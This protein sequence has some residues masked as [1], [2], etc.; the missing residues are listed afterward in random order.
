M[1]HH[2]RIEIDTQIL[3][4]NI[5]LIKQFMRQHTNSLVKYCLPVKANA[6]GHGLV[7]TANVVQHEVDYFGVAQADEGIKLRLAG[8]TKPILVFG[9]FADD[10]IEQLISH[11]LEITVSSLYKARLIANFCAAN[12]CVAKVHVKIDTGMNRI[13]VRV[14]SAD[15]LIDFVT[16]HQCFILSGIYSHLAKSDAAQDKFTHKQIEQFAVIAL[17]YK[18]QYPELLCHLANSGGVTNY[19]SSCL[20]DMVRP[21][22]LTYGYLPLVPDSDNILAGIRPCFSVYSQVAYFK[23]VEAQQGISYNHQYITT[24][25]TRVVTIPV[26]YG[27]GYRRAL[28]N[29]GEVIIRGNKYKVAGTICMDMFM[30]DIGATGEAHVGDEVVLI[31]R[32]GQQTIY[33][34]DIATMCDTITYE[35]LCAFNERIPRVYI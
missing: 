10:Q 32:Q 27:D 9:A 23:V 16:Q 19:A 14:D 3:L 29:R 8:I 22:I 7:G 6:Y 1:Y 4:N 12:N 34:R 20:F 15:N 5:R 35:I 30:V 28:S 33:L 21:G 24:E 17:K 31:G 25:R 26:G 18:Q 13:G 2:T 11:N